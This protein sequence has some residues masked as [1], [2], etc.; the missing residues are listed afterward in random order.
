[1]TNFSGGCHL[2]YTICIKN[3]TFVVFVSFVVTEENFCKF[4]TIRN[5]NCPWWSH[6]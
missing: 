5:K 6:F 4:Q 2:A 3:I 1:M